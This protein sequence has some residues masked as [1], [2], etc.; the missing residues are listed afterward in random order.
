MKGK[1]NSHT[2][3][4]GTVLEF[5]ISYTKKGQNVEIGHL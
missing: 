1:V 5:E 3:S 2:S 4:M